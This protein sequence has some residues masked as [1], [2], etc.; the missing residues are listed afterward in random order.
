MYDGDPLRPLFE[1]VQEPIAVLEVGDANTD[2]SA[3]RF[4]TQ[5][6]DADAALHAGALSAELD[7]PNT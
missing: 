3:T 2:R 7:I 5:F 6:D 1:I 4:Q